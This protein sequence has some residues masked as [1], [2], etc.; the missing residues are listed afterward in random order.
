MNEAARQHLD[1]AVAYANKGDGFYAQAADGIIAAQK[2]DFSLTNEEIAERFDRSEAWVRTLVAWRTNPSS[3]TPT[4]YSGQAPEI[5]RRKTKQMLREAPI[6][7]IEKM[8]AE[9]PAER[10]AKIAT[11]ALQREGVPREIAKDTEQWEAVLDAAT[12]ASEHVEEEQKDK[13]TRGKRTEI[14]ALVKVRKAFSYLKDSYDA[15]HDT[16]LEDDMKEVL[17]N[18]LDEISQLA[19]WYRDYL[20]SGS[21]V[22]DDELGALLG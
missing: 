6:E 17:S 10:V 4:P 3:S 1:Q 16:D 13:R 21:S 18:R 15:A 20:E 11:A 5:N 14:A 9:L 7:E 8:V 2:A 12:E 19:Q 22:D